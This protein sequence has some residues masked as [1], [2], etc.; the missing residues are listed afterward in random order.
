MIRWTFEMPAAIDPRDAWRLVLANDLLD[1]LIERE[2][3]IPPLALNGYR[4]ELKELK[5]M[6]SGSSRF[7]SLVLLLEPTRGQRLNAVVPLEL[8]RGL[9]RKMFYTGCVS[10]QRAAMQPPRELA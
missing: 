3:E 9:A 6:V 7:S 1:E 10:I 8:G 2:A 4:M 5:A